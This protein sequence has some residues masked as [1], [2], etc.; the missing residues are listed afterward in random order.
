[1]DLSQLL[2]EI[3]PVAVDGKK[4][5]EIL[6]ITCDSRQVKEG[7]V[8][9]AV[10][11]NLQNGCDFIHDALERGAAAIVSEKP[12]SMGPN[13]CSIQVGDARIAEAKLAAG[14]NNFAA[15]SLRMV[16]ITG[17]NGKTT[18]SYMTRDILRSSGFAP[19]L[20]TTVLYQIG[21]RTIPASRTT[22]DAPTL[23]SLLGKMVA[24]DCD[25]AVMEVSSH[26]LDQDRTYGIDYDVAVFTNLTRDHL[27]YH[28][29]MDAY[30]DAKSKL[31]AS[32]GDGEKDAH[33]VVNV[34][35]EWGRKLLKI[36][37]PGVNVVTYGVNSSADVV[38]E[39][40]N[41][42]ISGTSFTIKSP[43]GD[44]Y[45]SASLLGRY[46]VYNMLA[47]AAAGACLGAEPRNVSAALNLMRRVP[48]RL[49]EIETGRDFQVFVDYAHTD[50][51]LDHVL[52]TLREITERNL[53][54]V[55]GCGGDRD[56]AKRPAM[57]RLAG[58]KADH[59]I[60]TS[61]NPRGESAD[62]IIEEILV[63]LGAE[64]SY[65]VIE[66]RRCAIR[67]ALAMAGKGDVVL[68]AGK[69]HEGFQEFAKITVPFDDRE[70]VLRGLE[71]L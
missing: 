1:M 55:F 57:G 17:T 9:V 56:P 23:H 51:A 62:Q 13:A 49:E 44:I 10:S 29:T 22:P 19:G 36:P 27:D 42:S 4:E 39:N 48:G 35:D 66:D 33:A 69:G 43:W 45:V 31:F 59:A 34:D 18:C 70:E 28:L 2:M 52:G 67:R 68:V 54:V 71:E 24:A 37:Q 50:D 30:F 47:S 14:F 8:F 61:D 25:S 58:E 15:D 41:L 20:V 5:Q 21:E 46:N 64:A 53:V 32:L 26:A 16:G 63:G 65:E 7:Y 38:A 12:G 40:I 6:G 11:G 60:I 3:D